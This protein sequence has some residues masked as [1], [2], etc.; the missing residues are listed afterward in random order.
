MDGTGSL[1]TATTLLQFVRGGRAGLCLLA[2]ISWTTVAVG[3]DRFITQPAPAARVARIGATTSPV[4]SP[5]PALNVVLQPA[6]SL[7]GLDLSLAG[8]EHPPIAEHGATWV[9]RGTVH[10]AIDLAAPKTD[11]RLDAGN[12]LEL[13]APAKAHV[14]MEPMPA[15]RPI[16]G[17]HLHSLTPPPPNPA[18]RAVRDPLAGLE[19]SVDT[20]APVEDF[21]LSSSDNSFGE[22][23][24]SATKL[25]RFQLASKVSRQI[26]GQDGVEQNVPVEP[27]NA[28]AGWDWMGARLADHLGHSQR[29]CNRGVFLSAREECDRALVLLARHL[30]H[31]SNRFASEPGFHAAQIALRESADF[32]SIHHAADLGVLKQIVHSHDTPVLKQ[33]DLHQVSPVTLSQHYYQFAQSQMIE[34]SQMHPWFSDILYAMG[35]TFQAEAEVLGGPASDHL[36]GKAMVYYRA[37][38]TI[39][40]RNALAANQAGFMLL[41]QGRNREAHHYLLASVDASPD[42]PALQN[43]VES[44]RRLGDRPVEQWALQALATLRHGQSLDSRLPAVELLDT[45]AFMAISPRN[46]GPGNA[47]GPTAA[48]SQHAASRL[49]M[50][51]TGAAI[52]SV[53]NVPR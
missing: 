20:S 24:Q 29:L 47:A 22:P 32:T 30:D 42:T 48:A 40:P 36:R 26:L 6:R 37:A 31:V 53:P 44:S 33:S 1:N 13:A 3:E 28:A 12:S 52:S 27:I 39:V 8:E 4:E 21:N 35:R 16:E 11:S 25:Q 14:S 43:L 17:A 9:K 45:S 5:R 51:S 7:K 19:S 38:L 50:P 41:Q 23:K 10:S 2:G 49:A 15:A 46:I 34:A 18:L